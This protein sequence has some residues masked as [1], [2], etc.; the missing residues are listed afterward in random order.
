LSAEP[1]RRLG[2]LI[3]GVSVVILNGASSALALRG[4][5]ECDIPAV[6]ALRH[7]RSA[8]DR[9]VAQAGAVK[10]GGE[11]F[12]KVVMI[13]HCVPLA[14][15]LAQPHPEPAVLREDIWAREL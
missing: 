3:T 11:V 7:K 12:L 8:T 6:L 5:R 9:I 2:T 13:Q 4:L 10:I 1:K 15:L 14:A